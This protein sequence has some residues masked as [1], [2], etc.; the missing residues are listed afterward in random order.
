MH[1]GVDC[2][3]HHHSSGESQRERLAPRKDVRKNLVFYG[4]DLDNVR[5]ELIKTNDYSQDILEA[6]VRSVLYEQLNI[7][8]DIPMDE[9]LDVLKNPR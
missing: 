4:V 1:T 7:T 6:R 5:M 3:T 2:I 9:V 8:P